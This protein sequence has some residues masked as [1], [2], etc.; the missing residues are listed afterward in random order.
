[1]MRGGHHE[2]PEEE[3]LTRSKVTTVGVLALVL[4]FSASSLA[5]AQDG[6]PADPVT[7]ANGEVSDTLI[8]QDGALAT[9]EEHINV[10][11]DCDWAGLMAQYPNNV[12]L[13]FVGNA[14]IHGREAVGGV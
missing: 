8:P 3:A 10:L 12:E 6:E 7:S 13:H 2:P 4:A 9:Y 14:N 5:M 11:N 1:M